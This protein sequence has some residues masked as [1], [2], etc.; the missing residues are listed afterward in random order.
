MHALVC[1]EEVE[2][3][4]NNFDGVQVDSETTVAFS[5][6]FAIGD[7]KTQTLRFT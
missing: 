7:Q 1:I 5:G 2:L 4:S 3:V 6:Y